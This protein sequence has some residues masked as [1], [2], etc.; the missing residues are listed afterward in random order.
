MILFQIMFR[1]VPYSYYCAFR[2]PPS[3]PVARVSIYTYIYIYVYLMYCVYV[4][5]SIYSYIY[6]CIYMYKCGSRKNSTKSRES[7]SHALSEPCLR[8]A[9]YERGLVAFCIRKD[10][11][12]ILHRPITY[13]YISLSI[14]KYIFIFMHVGIYPN[15]YIYMYIYIC[16][17]IYVYIYIYMYV[18]IYIFIY[19]FIYIYICIYA[20]SVYAGPL[21]GDPCVEACVHIYIYIYTCDSRL[22][23]RQSIREAQADPCLSYSF[24]IV[25]V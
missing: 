5:I 15:I 19:I 21:G 23:R 1:I 16:I 4:H 18:Y 20:I 14:Y 12:G 22:C 9:P 11:E 2:N 10:Q 17:F 25:A 24:R 3:L 6:V 8:S 7:G 13:I